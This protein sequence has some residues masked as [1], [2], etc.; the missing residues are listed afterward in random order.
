MKIF[1]SLHSERLIF[2]DSEAS[3]LRFLLNLKKELAF[4]FYLL[5]YNKLAISIFI[6]SKQMKRK[7]SSFYLELA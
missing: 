6:I 7:N 2:T 1:L 5:V 4:I 3:F